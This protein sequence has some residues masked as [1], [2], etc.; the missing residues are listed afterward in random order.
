MHICE[1]TLSVS[2]GTGYYCLWVHFGNHKPRTAA[3][4]ITG[5]TWQVFM[6]SIELKGANQ[7]AVIITV[8][9]LYKM[10]TQNKSENY[11]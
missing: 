9:G 10:N 5:D 6:C 7:I 1:I 4:S 3:F 2:L 8:Y 11:Y